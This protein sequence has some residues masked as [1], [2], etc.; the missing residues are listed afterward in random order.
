MSHL[1]YTD[2]P[3]L[4]ASFAASSSILHAEGATISRARLARKVFIHMPM[5]DFSARLS[6]N[7]VH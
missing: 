1:A 7:A 3:S 4:V 2:C 5:A 6:F